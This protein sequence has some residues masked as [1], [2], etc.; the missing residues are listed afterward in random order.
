MKFRI[1]FADQIVGT[2]SIIAIATLIFLVFFIGSKQKWFVKKHAFYTEVTSGSSLSEGMNIQYKGFGI[3]K[4]KKITLDDDDDVILHFYILDEYIDRITEGSIIEVSVSPIGL[5]SSLIFHPGNSKNILEDDSLIPELNSKLAKEI[6]KEG[7]CSISVSNDSIN[8]ILGSATS[9]IQDVDI[10][11]RQL[12]GVMSGDPEVTLTTT[13][14]EVNRILK[15]LANLTENPQGLIPKLLEDEDAKGSIGNLLSSI[16]KTMDDVNVLIA[17]ESP[18]VSI[19]VQQLQV[20]MTQ[21]QDVMEGL[22]NN[23]LLKN[24]ISDRPEKESATPKLREGDF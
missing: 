2:L 6:I 9:L 5:G 12:N 1:K 11:I 18:D 14:N 10:L 3:G 16:N 8:T 20:L 4:L 23:P 19:L 22:K 17:S 24:G 7:K 15:N 13:I 21:A